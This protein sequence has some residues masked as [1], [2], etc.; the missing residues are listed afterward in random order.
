MT[1]T[2]ENLLAEERSSSAIGGNVGQ[3]LINLLKHSTWGNLLF[4]FEF[5][6]NALT[7]LVYL[8]RSTQSGRKYFTFVIIF[9]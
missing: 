6:F 3:C 2:Q 7:N 4:V 5:F 9:F 8:L 1:S